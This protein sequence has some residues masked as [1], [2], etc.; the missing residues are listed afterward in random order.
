[1]TDDS[2][3]EQ[4]AVR[5]D[6]PSL[7]PE[8]NRILTEELRKR[9]GADSVAMPADRPHTERERHGG[10]PGLLVALQENRVAA[11]LGVFSA[12]VFGAILALTTESWWFLPLVVAIGI[13]GTLVV[14][15]LMVRVTGETEHLPPEVAA[16]LE[17]EGVGDPDRLFTDLVA[18][19]G[20]T[21]TPRPIRP[22]GP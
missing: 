19:Y 3:I 6:D 7:S 4:R 15:V 18:E 12:I 20:G 16:R 17:D 8:A 2:N 10:R 1:M 14:T 11:T 9:I 13:A 22:V 5:S 21:A